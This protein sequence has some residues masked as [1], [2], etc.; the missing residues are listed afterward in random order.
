MNLTIKD[1]NLTLDSKVMKELLTANLLTV[2]Q[3]INQLKGMYD[4]L[5]SNLL[6]LETTP[7]VDLERKSMPQ[8][9]SWSGL[10]FSDVDGLSCD[11]TLAP[12]GSVHFHYPVKSKGQNKGLILEAKDF[13]KHPEQYLATE[14]Q[15]FEATF[16][17]RLDIPN[18]YDYNGERKK[19]NKFKQTKY[20]ATS[21]NKEMYSHL[22]L[23]IELP[24]NTFA[25]NVY[26]LE[27]N[28]WQHNTLQ[29]LNR[30]EDFTLIF[31][32]IQDYSFDFA[33][34]KEN[35]KEL[36]RDLDKG[37]RG[38]RRATHKDHEALEEVVKYAQPVKDYIRNA[39]ELVNEGKTE[40]D[41][42]NERL[43]KANK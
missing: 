24:N 33:T 14:L 28:H 21:F 43:A 9:L 3:E 10:W 30:V 27:Y 42:I 2:Q 41:R 29:K 31:S 22:M 11:G 23:V 37:V 15:N 4:R 8:L 5:Q 39:E 20:L 6:D 13:S 32:Q 25:F 18:P 26:D 7:S 19:Y 36:K 40:T 34:F 17:H 16:K 38:K 12:D 35:T 1:D